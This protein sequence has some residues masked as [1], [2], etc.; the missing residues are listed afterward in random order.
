MKSKSRS[1]WATVHK[2]CEWDPQ[3]TLPQPLDAWK[4]IELIRAHC[5]TIEYKQ[6]LHKMSSN[7]DN[8]RQRR[9]NG[10]RNS[11]RNGCRDDGF[12]SAGERSLVWKSYKS[13][14]GDEKHTFSLSTRQSSK[15][16]P[17][18][19]IKSVGR[20]GLRRCGI[21]LFLARFRENFYLISYDMAVFQN[22]VVF[23]SYQFCKFRCA[24]CGILLIFRAVLP[25]SEPPPH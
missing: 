25:F 5:A 14:A 9:L 7:S 17:F 21:A 24:I 11:K 12:R 15:N 3:F 6:A 20:K 22:Q 2:N 19:K 13:S 10:D 18:F 8:Q 4:A 1:G 16:Q 23:V